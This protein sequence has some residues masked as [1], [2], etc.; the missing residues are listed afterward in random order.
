MRDKVS[1][2][3]GQH[4]DEKCFWCGKDYRVR[5]D[6]R[7]R[8]ISKYGHVCCRQCF[9]K[10]PTFKAARKKAMLT[11]NPFKGKKHSEE[12]K[13]I[14]SCKKMG[15]PAWNK[16]L[17]KESSEIVSRNAAAT[18][19][20]KMGK[21]LKDKNPN[22]RGG[23]SIFNRDFKFFTDWLPFR[24]N[25]LKNDCNNCWKCGGN[26]NAKNLE[27]HHLTSKRKYPEFEYD[28]TN[29]VTLC[30]KCHKEF[31]KI[32]GTIKFTYGDFVNWINS[33]RQP[34]EKLVMC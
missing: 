19:K 5:K 14:L 28:E 1:V 11:N 31:H 33:T 20:S 15:I 22:W 6:A 8:Q 26:F 3:R 24:E 23:S 4:F 27:V 16:G 9:G 21:Q 7:Q 18:K 17:T 10:E 32:Y 30:K 34:H 12:T 13:A 29:C 25:I 2:E